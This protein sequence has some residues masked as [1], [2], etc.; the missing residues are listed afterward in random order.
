[1]GYGAMAAGVNPYL[2]PIPGRWGRPE[3][4]LSSTILARSSS[5]IR[6]LV[7]LTNS[8]TTLAVFSPS[9]ARAF[10]SQGR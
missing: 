5:L 7:C 3:N 9:G 6:S 8:F 1:M 4:P 10:A 2:S